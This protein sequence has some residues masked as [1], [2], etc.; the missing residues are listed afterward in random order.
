MNARLLI[1][2]TEVSAMWRGRCYGGSDAALSRAGARDA[3]ARAPAL[4]AWRPDVVIHS[5]LRRTR[6]LARLVAG[7]ANVEAISDSGWRERDF[8]HWEGKSWSAIYRKT[9]NAMDGMIDAP[10]TFRPGGGETT[11]ELADRVIAAFACLPAGRVAVVSH[12]GP[13]AALRGR[14][15]QLAISTW[16]TLIPAYGEA[17]E[18]DFE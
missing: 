8:G 1:R 4:A 7:I 16:P 9:G 6:D 15:G 18:L 17:W 12:G 2:H 14:Q 11:G 5:D 10:D 3:K 13:I